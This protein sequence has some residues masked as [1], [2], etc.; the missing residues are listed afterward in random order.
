MDSRKC[1]FRTSMFRLDELVA[2]IHSQVGTR[3]YM[4]QKVLEGGI[5]F[6]RDVFLQNNLYVCGL[7]LREILNRYK[8][9]PPPGPPSLVL[10]PGQ[11]RK[12]FLKVEVFIKLYFRMNIQQ[13]NLKR[14]L[15][16]SSLESL[17]P[18]PRPEH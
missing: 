15:S 1:I 9:I 3:R 16:L 5:N 2:N 4:T 8:N 18:A 14:S 12:I 6:S 10:Y 7:V 17:A 11:I 13:P